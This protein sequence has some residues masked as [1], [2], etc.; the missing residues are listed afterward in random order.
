MEMPPREV[1][2]GL[3]APEYYQL[4]IEYKKM[5]W[6]EQARDSLNIAIEIGEE[7]EVVSAARQF[8]KTKIPKYPVPLLA[9]Q[10]FIEGF[11]QM[12]MGDIDEAME[13]FEGLVK[14]YPTF[15][16][17]YGQ[18][19]VLYLQEGEKEKA[20]NLLKVALEI[21]PDYVNGWLH[22]ARANGLAEDFDAAKECVERALIVDPSDPAAKAL[23][24]ELEKLDSES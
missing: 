19:S 17:G 7:G 14:D 11:N 6:I 9:E 24:A 21:N 22:L 16:W 10:R 2:E 3:S 15:E 23:M 1:P 18:L 4:A 12:V 20:K 13:T 8:L 5:G